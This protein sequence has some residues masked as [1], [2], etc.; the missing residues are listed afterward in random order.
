MTKT[1]KVL[2]T[3]FFTVFLSTQI[4]AQEHEGKFQLIQPNQPTTNW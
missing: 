3:L 1:I 4:S 2:A